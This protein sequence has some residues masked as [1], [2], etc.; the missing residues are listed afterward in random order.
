MSPQA[1]ATARGPKRERVVYA[2][3]VFSRKPEQRLFHAA[4]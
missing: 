1:L 4:A 3:G 2:G